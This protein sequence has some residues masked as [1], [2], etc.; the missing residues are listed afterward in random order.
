MMPLNPHVI[1][2]KDTRKMLRTKR[3]KKTPPPSPRHHE[4]DCIDNATTNDTEGEAQ[5][6]VE[7][8]I[9]HRILQTWMPS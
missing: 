4:H 9:C 1:R 5:S 2:K 3:V 6:F 8:G 7:C